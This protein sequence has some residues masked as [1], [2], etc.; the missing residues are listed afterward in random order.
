[1]TKIFAKSKS[2]PFLYEENKIFL[3]VNTL[4]FLGSDSIS[5]AYCRIQL[6]LSVY[7]FKSNFLFLL[8]KKCCWLKYMNYWFD[9]Y[10]VHVR[11]YLLWSR[12]DS[13]I[14]CDE[15]SICENKI[16][17]SKI[18][19]WLHLSCFVSIIGAHCT[20]TLYPQWYLCHSF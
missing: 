20:L 6:N 14:H 5:F 17:Q 13:F 16:S 10:F 1:M 12:F 8:L 3:L 4:T 7:I 18:I 9:L 19:F 2:R 11:G 15:K